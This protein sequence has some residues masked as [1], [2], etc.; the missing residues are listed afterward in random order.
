MSNLALGIQNDNHFSQIFVGKGILSMVHKPFANGRDLNCQR[1]N[2]I[3]SS[4]EMQ[5]PTMTSKEA[6]GR[7]GC[8]QKS[9]EGS[10][11]R[12]ETD[13]SPST[14]FCRDAPACKL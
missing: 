6:L 14:T 8:C 2:K 11:E 10:G 4:K 5:D 9:Q 7:K 12:Q 3:W 1:N 13:V